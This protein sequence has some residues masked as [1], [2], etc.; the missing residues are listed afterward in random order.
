MAPVAV[1][2]SHG[3]I[4]RL[5]NFAAFSNPG[6]ITINDL[7]AAS[8]YPSVIAVSGVGGSL[9]KA[10]VTLTNLSHASPADIRALV[11][12]PVQLDTLIM[13]HAGG[14][15]AVTNITLTFD[16]AATTYLS[17]NSRLTTGTN[18]PTRWFMPPTPPP[19]P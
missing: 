8:P 12:S 1:I 11:V 4:R 9:V 16:D 18:K 3:R 2:K 13:A 15:N 7:A 14:Q 5:R 6:M 19:F 17:P 10:T